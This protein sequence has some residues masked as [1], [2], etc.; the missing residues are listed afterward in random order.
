[1]WEYGCDQNALHRIYS[2]YRLGFTGIFLCRKCWKTSCEKIYEKYQ[3]RD[4]SQWWRVGLERKRVTNSWN[5]PL[6][7]GTAQVDD[8]PSV[9]LWTK[10][11]LVRS[12]WKHCEL[13]S[14]V[15]QRKEKC[16]STRYISR[17]HQFST[18]G[19]S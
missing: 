7:S 11:D 4:Y 19:A 5:D 10:Q 6:L 9:L 8:G 1:M 3:A 16:L 14:G 18:E 17:L 13:G 12:C 2:G 15:L